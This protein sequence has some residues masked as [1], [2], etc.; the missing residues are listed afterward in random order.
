PVIANQ[1]SHEL[2]GSKAGSRRDLR[3]LAHDSLLQRVHA[4]ALPSSPAL[5]NFAGREQLASQAKAAIGR[6]AAAMV[7]P[8]Q[9]VIVDGGTT[10]RELARHLP[11]D[12]RATVVTHSPTIALELVAHPSVEV[13]LIGGRLF[14][15]SVVAVGAAAIEAI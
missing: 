7:Q 13:I 1:L 9:V 4:G 3:E 6:A 10:T 2:C 15:H 11:L 5:V 12:L 14:K 8:G